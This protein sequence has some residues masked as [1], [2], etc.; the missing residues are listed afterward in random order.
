MTE[1]AVAN[2]LIETFAAIV[3][4]R[5]VHTGD[6]ATRRFRKGYRYGDGEVLAA[7]R[8]GTLLEQWQLL[9]AC[10]AAEVIVIFQAA[11]TGLT[12]GSTPFGTDYDRPIVIINVMRINRI[13][14]ING[15]RQVIAL[16]GATLD[17]LEKTLRP[18]G[19]EPHSVIGSS[20]IG[21]SVTGGVCNNSGGSLIRRGP[22]FT[23]V[24]LFAQVSAD[25]R[26]HLV[27]HLGVELGGD[28]ETILRRLDNRDYREAD[29]SHT[30]QQWASDR[31]YSTHVRDISAVTPARFNADPRR[32]YEA[33]GSAGRIGVFAVRLDTFEADTDVT[34]FYIGTDEPDQLSQIRRDI[35]SRFKNLPIAGEYIHRDAYETAQEYGKDLYLFIRAFGTDNVPKAFAAKS[36]FDGVAEKIGLGASLSDHVLTGLARLFPEHLPK[37]LNA[38]RDRFTHHLLL[39]VGGDGVKEARDYLRSRVERQDTDYFE[40]TK[41][42]GEAAFLQRFTVGGAVVRYRATHKKTVEDIVALDVALPRNLTD[43]FETLPASV[44]DRIER[45]IYCGHFFCHVL[46]QEYLAKKGVDCHQLEADILATLDQRGAQYPAEHNVGHLY[47][48]PPQLEA[49][50]RSLDPTNTF[51]P[52]IGKT[53]RRKMWK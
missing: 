44:T 21:A 23:Q 10:V 32:H 53:S 25:G 33:S 47:S 13:D 34:V 3:G 14:L 24:S 17:K 45:T 36:W 31:E 39:K 38:Y 9:Q 30:P 48:A 51:N 28:P 7:V 15:G 8:P 2:T 43:W 37:R 35:L 16:P 42:E 40:C 52:G 19:R 18:I 11:N 22:A 27:N 4:R 5:Y 26:L 6:Q 12:G 50:Y 20:C 46:H 49:F 41:A 1:Q 29:I